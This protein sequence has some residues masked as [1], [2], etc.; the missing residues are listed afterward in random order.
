MELHHDT[1]FLYRN[2][3]TSCELDIRLQLDCSASQEVFLEN[4]RVNS[5]KD[6]PWVGIENPHKGKAIIVAN[7]PSLR[8]T[9]PDVAIS[10]ARGAKVFACNSAAHFLKAKNVEPDYQMF[11][12]AH[13]D[14]L[15]EFYDADCHL[16]ASIVAPEMVDR[17]RNPILWHPWVE[18][19][20]GALP[21]GKDFLGIN[22]GITILNFSMSVLDAMGY[23]D[24][25]IHGAD[26]SYSDEVYA[27]GR[28][29]SPGA[30]ACVVDFDGKKYFTS[31]DLKEQVRVFMNLVKILP[32]TKIV[33][34]GSG[35]LP[36]VYR[37]QL[38]EESKCSQVM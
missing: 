31:Y 2:P 13:P 29:A 16:F 38:L 15:K 32:D 35:L 28:P 37:A 33:V 4:A 3:N 24:Y 6:I 9:W 8:E 20:A 36:D 30:L 5:R 1:G 34:H 23:R 26:S 21:R 19:I 10:Q 17:S 25:E 12:D 18:G 14:S 11:M 7:G 27:D 22:G